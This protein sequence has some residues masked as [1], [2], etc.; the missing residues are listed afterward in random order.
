MRNYYY[1]VAGLLDIQFEDSKVSVA[2]DQFR[3]EVFDALSGADRKLMDLILL[4]N[5]CRTFLGSERMEELSAVVKAQEPCPE[6]VPQFMYD[7]VQ[8]YQDDSWQQYAA[9]AQDRLWAMFY[10]YALG[11]G[12]E[13]VSNWYRFNLDLKNIQTAITA[14]KYELDVRNLLIGDG[15]VAQALRTS[16]ARDWGLSQELPFW[17]DIMR[18]Q[19]A[20]DLNDRERKTDLLRWQWLEE[21][22]FFNYFTIERLFAYMVQLGIVERWSS[23]DREEGQKLFRRLIGELKE[24]TEVPQEFR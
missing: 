4:E 6:G 20:A 24:Q 10:Q 16:G 1:L 11:C 13:F 18:L 15:E 12:N 9:F 17:D 7:F 23:L 8:E 19:E 14:R 21:H 22:S 5:D 2:V 3:T